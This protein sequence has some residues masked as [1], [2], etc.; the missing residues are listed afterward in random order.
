MVIVDPRAMPTRQRTSLSFPSGR[1]IV[2]H[3]VDANDNPIPGS[4]ILFSINRVPVGGVRSSA[5]SAS[6]DMPESSVVVDVSAMV[7]QF[8]QSAHLPPGFDTHIFRFSQTR[9]YQSVGPPVASCPDGTSGQPCVD[10][11]IGGIIVRIC[12]V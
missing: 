8:T 5:G 3:V 9:V 6:L 7:G 10:C 1:R 4:D 12:A 11:D 2:I